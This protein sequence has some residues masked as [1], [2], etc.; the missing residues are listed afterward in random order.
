MLPTQ[1]VMLHGSLCRPHVAG[2]EAL[3]KNLLF[4]LLLYELHWHKIEKSWL[5]F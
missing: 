3:P 2:G 5:R 4:C 1:R